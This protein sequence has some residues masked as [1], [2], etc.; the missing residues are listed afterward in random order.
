[1]DEHGLTSIVLFAHDDLDATRLCVDEIRAHTPPESYELIVVGGG[2]GDATAEWARSEPGV[3]F[4]PVDLRLG[5]AAAQNRGIEKANGPNV[6]LL[7]SHV[8]V[9]AGWLPLLLR[10]LH[11]APD[12][13]AVGPVSNALPLQAVQASYSNLE[14]LEL[15]AGRI[16]HHD[17]AIWDQRLRLSDGCLLLKRSAIEAVGLLDE[18]FGRGGFHDDDYCLRLTSAGYRLLLCKGAFVHLGGPLLPVQDEAAFLALRGLENKLF[19]QKWG[20]EVTYS[21]F[22][23]TE[24]IAMMGEHSLDEPLRILELGCACGA[25]LLE[26]RNR[27]PNAELFGIE[28]NEGAAAVGSR[29]GDIRAMD[30]QNPL[31]YEEDFFDYVILA[32]VLEHLSDPWKVLANLKRHLKPT[33]KVIASIPNVM[34]FSVLRDVINGSWTYQDA[35]ILDRTHLRFFTLSEIEA[36]FQGAGYGPR[37]YNG[38]TVAISESDQRWIDALSTLSSLTGVEQY[39]VYQYLVSAS[40]S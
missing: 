4:L 19:T 28:L 31:S 3:T 32:D 6:A 38:T 21:T 39:Q 14:E 22:M 15:A 7:A 24:V 33:G 17:P 8:L 1:M 5:A 36:M 30:A 2:S 29:F 23:R 26:I 10:C 27:Y 16:N 9:T 35:G 40:R 34:H 20:F 18:Q 13:G 11:S 25:T 37:Q 12:V